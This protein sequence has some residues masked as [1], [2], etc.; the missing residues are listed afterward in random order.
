MSACGGGFYAMSL[1]RVVITGLG[2]VAPECPGVDAFWR[3]LFS[4]VSAISWV[5]QLNGK[6]LKV[7]RLT[8]EIKSVNKGSLAIPKKQFRYMDTVSQYGFMAAREALESAGLL[9]HDEIEADDIGLSIGLFSGAMSATRTDP[10]FNLFT[11]A[12]TAYYG[13]VLGNITIPLGI[14]GPAHTFLSLDLAGTDAIG[15]AYEIIRH[16]KARAML[17][18]GSDSAFSVFMLA[19]F[20][21]AGLLSRQEHPPHLGRGKGPPYSFWRVWKAPG[22]AGEPSMPKCLVMSQAQMAPVRQV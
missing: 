20:D 16:G 4:G 12:V 6:E 10:N 1:Q 9:T 22:S 17:A 18:G 19:G 21:Q 8:A 15:Y 7:G 13:S 5:T 11:A 2:I 14:S 3:R